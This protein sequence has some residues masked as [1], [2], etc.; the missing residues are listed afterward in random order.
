MDELDLIEDLQSFQERYMKPALQ[1][2]CDAIAKGTLTEV[3]KE[4]C[5]VKDNITTYKSI[6]G[7]HMETKRTVLEYKYDMMG[8]RNREPTEENRVEYL[9]ISVCPFCGKS[10]KE[11][12]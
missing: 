11:E 9:D 6:N 4:E 7:Y 2:A 8:N 5:C 3:T 1:K 12:E 10:D